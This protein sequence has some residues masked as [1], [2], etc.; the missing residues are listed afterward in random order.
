[1]FLFSPVAHRPDT[2]GSPFV[3]SVSCLAEQHDSK[4]QGSSMNKNLQNKFKL[5][6]EILLISNTAP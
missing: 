2:V 1:M 5:F 6:W 3:K 4:K